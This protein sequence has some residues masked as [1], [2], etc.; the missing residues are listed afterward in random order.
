MEFSII[1]IAS[2]VTMLNELV[3]YF[4]NVIFKKDINK[5]I[6]LCSVIFGI[7]LGIAG[8]YVKDVEMGNNLIEAIF[9]GM[10]AGSSAT[11]VNQ[12]KKQMYKKEDVVC[13]ESI[14]I[15]PTEDFVSNDTE[16]FDNTEE[17]D[18][19]NDITD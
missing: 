7:L 4:G 9:I 13:D 1:T 18:A 2:F 15:E 16:L 6:P 17:Q 19:E 11:G 5:W 3:K 14:D 12:I 10:S 8:Y